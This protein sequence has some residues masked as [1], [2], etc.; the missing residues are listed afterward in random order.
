MF[1]WLS[2]RHSRAGEAAGIAK[3][4]QAAGGAFRPR[5]SF[6]LACRGERGRQGPHRSRAPP[7]RPGQARVWRRSASWFAAPVFRGG[8]EGQGVCGWR[9]LRSRRA[10]CGHSATRS[11]AA[12]CANARFIIGFGSGR[13]CAAARAERPSVSLLA[14]SFAGVLTA[15]APPPAPLPAPFRPAVQRPTFSP[16]RSAPGRSLR[17]DVRVSKGGFR[18]GSFSRVSLVLSALSALLDS[19]GARIGFM[20]AVTSR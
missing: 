3:R 1:L 15:L 10:R 11:P 4:R 5:R 18:N 19:I 20:G 16:R 17:G 13:H 6:R 14:L 12:G 9:E 2:G 7:D 8:E